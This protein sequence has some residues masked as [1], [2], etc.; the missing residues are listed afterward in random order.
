[1][2]LTWPAAPFATGYDV[3]L[4]GVTVSANQPGT[5]YTTGGALGV[6]P[7]TWSVT[8][9][10]PQGNASGC[11]TWTFSTSLLGCYCIP[12]TVNGCNSG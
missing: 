7:H 1:M 11:T 2:T 10:S 3:V 9:L 4:D 6:G 8:P 5:S 12:T